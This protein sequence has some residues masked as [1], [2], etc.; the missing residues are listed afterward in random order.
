ME[1]IRKSSKPLP[2]LFSIRTGVLPIFPVIA[3]E[4]SSKFP[5]GPHDPL[6]VSQRDDCLN[7]TGSFCGHHKMKLGHIGITLSRFKAHAASE[8]RVWDL[9]ITKLEYH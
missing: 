1:G 6:F 3:P 4:P 7:V 5:Q 9:V 8:S 2:D